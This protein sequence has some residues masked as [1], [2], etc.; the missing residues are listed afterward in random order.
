MSYIL[1]DGDKNFVGC[2]GDTAEDQFTFL[3]TNFEEF[4]M[5]K[6]SRE[7]LCSRIVEMNESIRLKDSKM[8]KILKEETPDLCAITDKDEKLKIDLKFIVKSRPL[9]F[10]F[11]LSKCDSNEIGS[12][13]AVGLMKSMIE[14][15]LVIERMK[16]VIVSKDLEIEEY[17]IN[18]GTLIRGKF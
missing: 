7:T 12:L 16:K 5:E 11:I 14:N 15:S 2:F 8:I 18:G 6:F 4:F 3:A 9:S 17:K 10:Y 13:F 1:K